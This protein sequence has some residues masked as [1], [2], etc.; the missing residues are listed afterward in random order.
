MTQPQGASRPFIFDTEFDASGEV[1]TPSAWK[2]A[3]R[4]YLPAEV[5]ALVAQARLEA[6][7]Q[8]L[9][10][11]EN[12]RAMALNAVAQSVASSPPIWRSPPRAPSRAPRS[13][14]FRLRR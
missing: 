9:D 13:T 11:V 6:R 8:A 5:D 10:E 1:V 7:Q 3:K 14:A 2:P 4:T 12:L